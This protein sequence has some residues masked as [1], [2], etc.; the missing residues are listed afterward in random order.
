VLG[1]LDKKIRSYIGSHGDNLAKL[2]EAR[3]GMYGKYASP[4]IKEYA[5]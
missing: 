2:A 3:F 1:I 4:Y 5:K